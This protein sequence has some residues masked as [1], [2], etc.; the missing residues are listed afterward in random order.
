MR[1]V[2]TIEPVNPAIGVRLRPL[3]IADVDV[4]VL[5][6]VDGR[7]MRP[8]VMPFEDRLPTTEGASSW[9]S[10]SRHLSNRLLPC[11]SPFLA[12]VDDDLARRDEPGGRRS[13]VE[14]RSL[15]AAGVGYGLG[16]DQR[17]PVRPRRRL[18]RLEIG[19][20]RGPTIDAL[21]L[22]GDVDR[23]GVLLDVLAASVLD[24][25]VVRVV[26]SPALVATVGSPIVASAI[27]S[28]F[29][30][31]VMVMLATVAVRGRCRFR[32]PRSPE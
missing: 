7:T 18:D 5:G 13:R 6:D 25:V 31:E 21:R 14:D 26:A 24:E 4:L 30:V 28:V 10:E 17:R 20:R 8:V 23:D 29:V 16:V 2:A 1:L 9:F 11:P 27:R 22:P 3:C 12:S 32:S 15:P 19:R